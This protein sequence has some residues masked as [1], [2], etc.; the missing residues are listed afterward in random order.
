[1]PTIQKPAL[2]NLTQDLLQKHQADSSVKVNGKVLDQILSIVGDSQTASSSSIAAKLQS[3]NLL[4]E[5][6]LALA[7]QG[8][9]A[10]EMG[11][12]KTLLANPQMTPLLDPVSENFLKA[13]VG[14]EPLQPVDALGGASR[15]DAVGTVGQNPA[16][17]AVQ[18][19]R[20]LVKS[21]QIDKYYDAAIGI[22]DASLKDE[23]MK[24][25]ESLPKMPAGASADD[26]VAIATGKE[27]PLEIRFE[28]DNTKGHDQ[29]S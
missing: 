19:M 27:R 1:M 25:F 17:A 4:P 11:D 21:G 29:A 2:R 13:L 24:L 12:I 5:E 26:F 16:L 23:A 18:K 22:G 28:R 8:L 9:D 10:S 6:K 14:L 7:K 20:D 15:V 3:G